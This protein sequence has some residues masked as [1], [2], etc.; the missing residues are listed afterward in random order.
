MAVGTAGAT[1]TL[2]S[3]GWWAGRTALE[4]PRDP[5]VTEEPVTIPVREGTIGRALNLTATAA[6]QPIGEIRSAR[7][8]I[9]TSVAATDA[10][11]AEAAQLLSVDLQPVV[12]VQ[13]AVP[14]FRDLRPEVEGPDVLQLEAFLA[15]AGFDPGDQDG[16]YGTQTT[17]AVQAWQRASEMPVTGT[18]PLGTV[19][20]TPNVP[21]RVRLG[22][23]VGDQ[24][25]PGDPLAEVLGPA[26]QFAVPVTNEQT[27]LIPPAT[28]VQITAEDV[29][30]QAQTAD[31]LVAEDGSQRLQL[32]GQGGAPVCADDCARVSTD[33]TSTWSAS[34]LLVPEVTGPVVPAAAVQ[35]AAD[36]RRYVI[37]A[38]GT[39]VDVQVRASADGLAQVDG[40]D[41]GTEVLI[42]GPTT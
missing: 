24:V 2:V 31:I 37:T 12:L 33:R 17:Q 21:A 13:G 32:K 6:W 26:P 16:D 15:R 19:V 22:V 30:W 38:D 4:P 35:T 28:P 8:G 40:V 14:A 27:A 25:S 20:F 10:I 23:D 39:E 34:I 42:P 36:G 41:V 11:L 29:T 9:V 18:V 5:L 3:A 7:A 1:V